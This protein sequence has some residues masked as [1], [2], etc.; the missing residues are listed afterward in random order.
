MMSALAPQANVSDDRDVKEKLPA[1]LNGVRRSFESV[2]FRVFG[3]E[4]LLTAQMTER[5][6][7]AS[8]GQMAQ[9]VAFISYMWTQRNGAWQLHDIRIVSASALSRALK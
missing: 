3:P 7:N 1:G 8:A 4:A 9:D 2:S 6:D 5:M